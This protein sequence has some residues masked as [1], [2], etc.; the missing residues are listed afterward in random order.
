MTD[1]A[2]DARAR[3]RFPLGWWGVAMLVATEGALFAVMIGSYFYL[4]FKNLHWPPQGIPE[5]K[6]VVPLIL[7]AVGASGFFAVLVV[8]KYAVAAIFLVLMGLVLVAWHGKEP[9]PA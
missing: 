5:P 8:Q 9:E 7:L 3:E 6:L 2:V 1:V 4:R